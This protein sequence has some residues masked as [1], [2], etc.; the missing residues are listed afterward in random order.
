MTA[1]SPT[2]S[3]FGLFVLARHAAEP[4]SPPNLQ[5]MTVV[6]PGTEHAHHHG[7]GGT[8]TMRHRSMLSIPKDVLAASGAELPPELAQIPN[9]PEA[10]F[11]SLDLAGW[12]L[13]LPLTDERKPVGHPPD[14]QTSEQVPGPIL[15]PID[16]LSNLPDLE[17]ITGWTFDRA[18]LGA[19][20]DPN[21][22]A[23]RILLSGGRVA[24]MLRDPAN[25]PLGNAVFEFFS[26]ETIAVQRSAEAVSYS[27]DPDADGTVT[28]GFSR[29]SDPA[30]AVVK[31]RLNLSGRT[32]E[33]MRIESLPPEED[34]LRW[35]CRANPSAT[36]DHFRQFAVVLNDKG[37][38]AESKR[39]PFMRF[40]GTVS[41]ANTLES[42]IG[43]IGMELFSGS[44]G[45]HCPSSQVRL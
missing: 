38:R 43:R 14:E 13:H 32:G 45:C 11:V 29:L 16:P 27:F 23:S 30:G 42:R 18:L 34:D 36:L 6:M 28:L 39:M 7:M 8:G 15:G 19:D 41:G 5:K 1:T 40:L 25:R 21:R 26:I 10:G 3:I 12:E 24:C 31:L 17:A 22:L 35:I 33:V 4:D 2:A 44:D 37:E 20:P 9:D